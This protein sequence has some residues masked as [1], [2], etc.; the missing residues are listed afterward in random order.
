[1]LSHPDG[2]DSFTAGHALPR[3]PKRLSHDH[4]PE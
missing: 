2:H 1:M 3:E 4:R